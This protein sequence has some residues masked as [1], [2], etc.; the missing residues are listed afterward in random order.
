MRRDSKSFASRRYLMLALAAAVVAVPMTM[1]DLSSQQAPNADANAEATLSAAITT[2]RFE[3]PIIDTQCLQYE[4]V[5]GEETCVDE[6]SNDISGNGPGV[7][8]WAIS[9]RMTLSKK[10]PGWDFCGFKEEGQ[11]AWSNYQYQVAAGLLTYPSIFDSAK[12]PVGQVDGGEGIDESGALNVGRTGLVSSNARFK[13]QITPAAAI[14][15]P[16]SPGS[17][18]YTWKIITAKAI[19]LPAINTWKL[20]TP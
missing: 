8:G 12:Y 18:E 3:A 5:E 7:V 4:T 10:L 9:V 20:V 17:S 2:Y 6:V 14:C 13:P 1:L 16:V 15:G 11:D 19:T